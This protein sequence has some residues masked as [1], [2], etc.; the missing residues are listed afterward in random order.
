MKR[1]IMAALDTTK[2]AQ[3][4][5]DN[6][7]THYIRQYTRMRGYV[8]MWILYIVT[9]I[10]AQSCNF[11]NITHTNIYESYENWTMTHIS[12]QNV[13]TFPIM[14]LCSFS[15]SEY[16]PETY[17]QQWDITSGGQ[18][19]PRI[20]L[21]RLIS[22]IDMNVGVYG[23]IDVIKVSRSFV[24]FEHLRIKWL[25]DSGSLEQSGH[26]ESIFLLLRDVD[27]KFISILNLRKIVLISG[28]R[29]L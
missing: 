28:L 10:L 17:L 14:L 13:Y 8:H 2:T 23:N 12:V 5:I 19:R 7:K 18:W 24:N 6:T 21:S 4:H 11:T 15:L 3:S 20:Y 25:T 9:L 16:I 26:I 1:H 22:S 27:N 29:I